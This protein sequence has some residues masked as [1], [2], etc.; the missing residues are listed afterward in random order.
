MD[1]AMPRIMVKMIS[2]I[3]NNINAVWS[4]LEHTVLY[5][6]IVT[7]L[8]LLKMLFIT[9]ISIYVFSLRFLQADAFIPW[10]FYNDSLDCLLR[11]VYDNSKQMNERT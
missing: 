5:Y 6:Y 7:I 3:P 11:I 10:S 8:D 4:L 9:E 1:S 2:F